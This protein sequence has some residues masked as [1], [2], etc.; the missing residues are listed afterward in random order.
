MP[1]GFIL[2]PLLLLF[3]INDLP[4]LVKRYCL[5][6]TIWDDTSFIRAIYNSMNMKQN[7]KLV[8]EITQ[9]WFKSNN[10]AIKLWEDQLHQFNKIFSY[11]NRIL[12]L[13]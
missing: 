6:N 4:Q 3:Y 8:L 12:Y 11:Y 2:G 9:Q 5:D 10:N 13:T 7:F 1:Q